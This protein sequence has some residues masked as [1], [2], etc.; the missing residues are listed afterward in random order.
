MLYIVWLVDAF[1]FPNDSYDHLKINFIF[2][3]YFSIKFNAVIFLPICPYFAAQH[4]PN[5][6]TE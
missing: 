3:S 2:V 4:Q 5:A 6:A 1:F